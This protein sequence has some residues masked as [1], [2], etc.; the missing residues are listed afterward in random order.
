MTMILAIMQYVLLFVLI[1]AVFIFVMDRT[2]RAAFWNGP[3]TDHFDGNKFHNRSEADKR[4]E[5]DRKA[6]YTWML[7]RD[8]NVWTQREVKQTKPQ[9]RV[10]GD[11]LIVTFIN[12]ATVLIQTQGKNII[13]DPMYSKRASPV[14]FI[15][16]KRYANPGVAFEDLPPIDMVLLSHNHYDH[17]DIATLRALSEKFKPAIFAPLGN[18]AYLASKGIE[19]SELDW[20]DRKSEGDFTLMFTPARHFSARALS[21]RDKTLWGG[22]VIE[23]EN[24]DIYFSGDTAYG[25]FISEIHQK[26]PRG[27]RLGLIPIGAYKP[28]AI[29]SDVHMNPEEAIRAAQELGVKQA[30]AIHFGTF[31][32][33][34]DGQ[35]E[36]TTTLDALQKNQ[37]IDIFA[38]LPNGGSITVK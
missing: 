13:T 5:H 18:K 9:E 20:W 8:K 15:G 28:E 19:A 6:I 1:V 36:P 33:A 37:G 17:M 26:Y 34:D 10:Y 31:K 38:A 24:G 2:F 14:S 25:S 29:M 12:H 16:P 32:L 3:V 35:D 22:Y 30:V 23:T 11:K 27:F 4:T 7:S 21:D